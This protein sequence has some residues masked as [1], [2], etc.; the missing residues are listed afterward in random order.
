AET[1]QVMEYC[2]EVRKLM[3]FDGD[4]ER[5]RSR[6]QA[7]TMN[8]YVSVGTHLDLGEYIEFGFSINDPEWDWE[9][10]AKEQTKA[11]GEALHER[12]EYVGAII[13]LPHTWFK[14]AE[15]P[16]FTVREIEAEA[17]VACFYEAKDHPKVV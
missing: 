7:K 6:L 14:E 13:G 10:I 2:S 4:R 5:L 9:R 8:R 17:L 16:H 12:V 3:I 11:V 1:G 15:K